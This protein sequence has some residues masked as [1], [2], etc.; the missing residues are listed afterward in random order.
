MFTAN[1]KQKKFIKKATLLNK[2]GIKC[3]EKLKKFMN[4]LTKIDEMYKQLGT[5]QAKTL[6]SH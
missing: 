4:K 5:Y 6:V 3:L 2:E 1:Y